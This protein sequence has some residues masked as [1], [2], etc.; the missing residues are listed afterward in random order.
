MINAFYRFIFFIRWKLKTFL[1]FCV[2]LKKHKIMEANITKPTMRSGLILGGLFSVNFLLTIPSNVITNLLNWVVIAV[3]VVA[4]LRLSKEYRDK[5]LEGFISYGK[6]FLFIILS[7]F[8]ASLISAFVKIIYFQFI[9]P[10]Y[11]AE[12]YNRTMLM[13]EQIGFPITDDMEKNLSSMLKPVPYSLL[14]IIGNMFY[15]L[16]LGLIMAAFVKKEKS[17]FEE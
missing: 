2:S 5:E 6:S 13:M 7:F 1:Y 8:Y 15:G 12:I 17:I 9:N 3:I 14:S 11:L 10:D 4:T 16:I